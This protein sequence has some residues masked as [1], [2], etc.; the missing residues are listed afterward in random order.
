MSF[1]PGLPMVMGVSSHPT[2]RWPNSYAASPSHTD[3]VT[4][5]AVQKSYF[6]GR[7]IPPTAQPAPLLTSGFSSH[8]KVDMQQRQR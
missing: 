1:Q 7:P 2:Q 8:R 4:W 6:Q 5:D 3:G